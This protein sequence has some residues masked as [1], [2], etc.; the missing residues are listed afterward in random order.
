MKKY[1]ILGVTL[2][3]FLIFS[4]LLSNCVYAQCFNEEDDDEDIA[5]I[6]DNEI[7]DVDINNILSSIRVSARNAIA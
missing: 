7:D 2:S 5:I 6:E 1:K 3:L 4:Q